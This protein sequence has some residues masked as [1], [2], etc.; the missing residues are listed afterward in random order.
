MHGE[1]IKKT[2]IRRRVA[3]VLVLFITWLE[4]FES[5]WGT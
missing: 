4:S 2:T 5:R 3:A 1:T